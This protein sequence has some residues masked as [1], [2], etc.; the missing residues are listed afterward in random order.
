MR[1]IAFSLQ[2][3][4]IKNRFVK[5]KD[6][7]EQLLPP[8]ATRLPEQK[9]EKLRSYLEEVEQKYSNFEKLL[10]RL[11]LGEETSEINDQDVRL[12]SDEISDIYCD[13]KAAIRTPLRSE[14]NADIRGNPAPQ[15]SSPLPTTSLR[16]PKF[17]LPHFSG[18]LNG[19]IYF[20]N[21]FDN[22]I[23]QNECLSEIE[24]FQYLLPSLR[25][26]ALNI[27]KSC[28]SPLTTIELPGI[29]FTEDIIILG[30]W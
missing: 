27:V 4:L 26:E 13:V 10:E 6:Y 17:G 15:A 16:L 30:V 25:G 29:C 14:E 8:P 12:Y 24:R 21:L 20:S 23:N 19:W 11:Y 18:D 2:V 22:T 28:P 9:R 7:I 5:I 3:E 1:Y